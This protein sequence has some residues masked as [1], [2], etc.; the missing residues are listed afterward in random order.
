MLCNSLAEGVER[1]HWSLAGAR[2]ILAVCQ[3]ELSVDLLPDSASEIRRGALIDRYGDGSAQDASEKCSDPLRGISSTQEDPVAD[4]DPSALKL[5]RAL[6]GK[7]PDFG[8]RRAPH[9]VAGSLRESHGSAI[10]WIFL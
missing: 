9:P 8:V 2:D 4:P 7:L 1:Q 10:P 6:R 3:Q 5:P